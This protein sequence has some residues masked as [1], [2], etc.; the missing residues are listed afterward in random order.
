M[1]SLIILSIIA[2]HT[3]SWQHCRDTHPVLISCSTIDIPGGM[4]S[5]SKVKT[6]EHRHLAA[7]RKVDERAPTMTKHYSLGLFQ[8]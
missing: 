4:L 8:S 7:T 3:L 6:E 5:L 1:P 2:V